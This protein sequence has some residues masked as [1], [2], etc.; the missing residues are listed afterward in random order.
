MT[1]TPLPALGH[2]VSDPGHFDVILPV[3][4]GYDA[5]KDKITQALADVTPVA[6]MAVKDVDVYPSSGKLVIGLRIAKASDTDANAGQWLYLSGG[7]QVDADGHAV[8]LSDLSAT[9]DNEEL[10]PVINA[11]T[12][13][14]RD[15]MSVDYGRRLSEPAECSEWEANP[16]AE[17][18]LPHDGA[19]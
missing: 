12:A 8:R 11:I 3:R 6:G 1:P 14:L 7:L 16:T 19:S 10:A 2:D 5:I 13:Q 18:R 4:I 9:T 17:G 15:K